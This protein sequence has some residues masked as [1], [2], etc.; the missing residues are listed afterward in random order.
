MTDKKKNILLI[1]SSI[2]F[3]LILLEIF[4]LFFNKI[5]NKNQIISNEPGYLL[6]EQGEVF[7][8]K[9][10]IVKYHPN[11]KIKTEAFFKVEDKFI[12]A[13]SYEITTNNFGLVQKNN[14]KKDL[15]SIL[16]LGDSFTEGQ[17]QP[18]WIDKFNGFFKDYQIINGGILATGPQ[19]FESMEEHISKFYNVK[20]VFFLF[21]GHDVRRNPYSISKQQFSCLNNYINCNGNEIFYGFPL[22]SKNPEKFLNFLSDTRKQNNLDLSF[23]KRIKIKIKNFFKNLNIVKIPHNFLREKFYKSKNI[24]IMKNFES[25]NNLYQKYKDNIYF[26]HLL[27]RNEIINGKEYESHYTEKYIRSLTK[28]YFSCKFENRLQNYNSLDGHPNKDGYNYLFNC[29]NRIM[30]NEIKYN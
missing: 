19:Q 4:F 22:N 7:Q 30:N 26:V 12:K 29:I 2:L 1:L 13:Y 11:K 17:G 28:N 21:I 3:T 20:K 10:K 5:K 16:F 23:K 24:K 9:D 8:N 18:A 15:P 25:I 14:L 6:Y 27:T